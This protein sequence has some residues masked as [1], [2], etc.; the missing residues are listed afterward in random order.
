EKEE[1]KLKS[2]RNTRSV[3][4]G[5][6]LFG[7]VGW[8]VS[9]PTL[10]GAAVGIWLDKKNPQHFSWTLTGLTTGLIAGCIIAWN[11]VNKE[12]KEIRKNTE[13]NDE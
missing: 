7:M 2:L 11:W 3:W 1:R 4:S 12:N 8:S 9:I 13:D 10:I 6:G 5:L